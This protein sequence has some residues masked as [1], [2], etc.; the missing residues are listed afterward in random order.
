MSSVGRGAEFVSQEPGQSRRLEERTCRRGVPGAGPAEG[1]PTRPGRS[2][3]GVWFLE[4]G[5]SPPGRWGLTE[6][7]RARIPA[8]VPRGGG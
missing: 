3:G 8:N 5:R 1:P 7:E 6:S 4:A 2:C